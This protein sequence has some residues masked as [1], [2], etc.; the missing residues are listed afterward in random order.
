MDNIGIYI[1]IAV[2]VVVFIIIVLALSYKK[3]PPNEVAVISGGGKLKMVSGKSVF[4]VPFIQRM[5]TLNLNVMQIDVKTTDEVPNKDF[6]ALV[7]DAVANIQINSRTPESLKLASELFLGRSSEDITRIAKDVLEGNMREIIGQLTITDLVHNRDQFA[8]KVKASAAEDMSR[9]GLEIINITIQNFS[10]R[11]NIIKDLGIENAS[12]IKKDAAIVRSKS[13]KEIEISQSNDH[14]EA[15]D[16]RVK[17]N[18]EIARMNNELKL[19][20]ERLRVES[21]KARAIA[22]SSHM[23]QNVSQ[24]RAI[25]IESEKA[26]V[27]VA[28]YTRDVET[29]N[30]QIEELKLEANVK[31]MA[32]ARK[33]EE[34]TK[35]EVEAKRVELQAKAQADKVK[36]E[37]EAQKIAAI[38][39][40]EGIKALGEA[41]ANAIQLEG[42]AIAASI[43]AKAE[44]QKELDEAG[45]L[46]LILNSK[47]LPEIAAALAEGYDGSKMTFYGNES[48]SN[49]M[50]GNTQQMAGILD[51]FKDSGMDEVLKGVITGKAT[52]KAIGESI[53]V[54]IKEDV[55]KNK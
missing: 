12:R 52:G 24:E 42:A 7:V 51:I 26:K 29:E 34:I 11:D 36:I 2:C 49:F 50:S 48:L 33:Y 15:N 40:A 16:V 25:R 23:L 17:N 1:F 30:I 13:E 44:A 3:I 27:E 35:L 47:V 4:V 14:K 55:L 39:E 10:D 37:A 19:E 28:K 46:D 8:E 32:D 53:K 45:K 20:E 41:K 54:D 21:E 43:K 31:K 18:L 38:A 22:E 9:L 6:I 5:D